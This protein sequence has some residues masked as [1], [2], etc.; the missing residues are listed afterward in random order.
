MLAGGAAASCEI[1]SRGVVEQS[2]LVI[3]LGDLARVCLQSPLLESIQPFPVIAP[4]VAADCQR[5]R[6]QYASSATEVRARRWL[7]NDGA[8]SEAR[9]ELRLISAAAHAA[10]SAASAAA[11]VAATAVASIAAAAATVAS[12]SPCAI[13]PALEP[14]FY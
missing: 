7:V 1:S 3:P 8:H 13:E 11:A 14:R 2:L 12:A 5:Q 9:I 6:S 10:A 4:S